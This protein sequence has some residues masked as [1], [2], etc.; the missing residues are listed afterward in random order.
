MVT[1]DRTSL[2]SFLPPHQLEGM[3]PQLPSG[4][5]HLVEGHRRGP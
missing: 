1:V 4:L 3:E 5:G 2:D